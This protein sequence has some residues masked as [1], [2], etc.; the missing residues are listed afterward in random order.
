MR[1]L[2][3][4]FPRVTAVRLSAVGVADLKALCARV[5]EAAGSKA[6]FVCVCDDCCDEDAEG[7]DRGPRDP[8]N[9]TFSC[10]I[11]DAG[12]FVE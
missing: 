3:A 5:R 10:G 7:S 4:A 8:A 1:S 12:E 6:V 2:I 9:V 11:L